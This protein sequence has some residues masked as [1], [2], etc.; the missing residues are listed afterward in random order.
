MLRSIFG[1]ITDA[2]AAQSVRDRV[3]ARDVT[4]SAAIP[5]LFELLGAETQE[6]TWRALKPSER[7]QRMIDAC[8]GWITAE[9]KT[10]PVLF[11]ADDF[12]W[13]DCES[14]AVIRS[15]AAAISNVPVLLVVSAR[16]DSDKNLQ[17]PAATGIRLDPLEPA[18]GAQILNHIMGG[19]A[20]NNDARAR[21]IARTAGNPLY[22]IEVARALNEV[23]ELPTT[24]LPPTVQ[25]II[26]AR[27]DALPSPE[28]ALLQAASVLGQEF[29]LSHLSATVMREEEGVRTSLGLLQARGFVQERRIFPEVSF[30]FD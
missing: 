11:L 14:E 12:Q 22:L 23:N 30:G 5:A 27:I 25:A 13:M 6:P 26:A 17:F 8:R 3:L 19:D 28:K 2:G 1:Q 16:A 4:L 29:E 20:G 15:V 7:R 18:D 10:R 21:L 9:C 24:T